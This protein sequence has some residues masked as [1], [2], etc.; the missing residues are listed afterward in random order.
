[1]E[2]YP[3][4]TQ[5]GGLTEGDLVSERDPLDGSEDVRITRT[6]PG[7]DLATYRYMTKR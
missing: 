3:H 2:V 7:R 1:M 4:D 5:H 6:R